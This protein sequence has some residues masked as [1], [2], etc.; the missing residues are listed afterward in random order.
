MC[1]A[2]IGA[3]NGSEALG[4]SCI[5]YLILGRKKAKHWD[6]L[7]TLDWT[8][9]G[10]EERWMY[11]DALSVPFHDLEFEINTYRGKVRI[12]ERIFGVAQQERRFADSA[13]VHKSYMHEYMS[14]QLFQRQTQGKAQA[15][16][17]PTSRTF[18][19]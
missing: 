18:T 13:D 7:A 8:G 15:Y 14:Q 12:I 1:S 17:F 3:R 9:L 5:P 19:R 10:I 4:A 16:L 6:M 2:V 11:L